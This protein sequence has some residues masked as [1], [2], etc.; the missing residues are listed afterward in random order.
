MCVVS[1]LWKIERW[2]DRHTRTAGIQIHQLRRV[3]NTA[4][5]H[6][7]ESIRS[8]TSAN[9]LAELDGFLDAGVLGLYP[10]FIVHDIL[11][12][13]SLEGFDTLLHRGELGNCFVRDDAD[14]LGAHV[15]QVH[16]YFF[17][18][19]WSLWKVLVLVMVVILG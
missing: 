5:A 13:F 18:A 19:T 16:A 10:H 14:A 15:G 1:G 9:L 2:S 8:L 11:D 17:G 3:N 6:S 4:S 7:Q 12:A